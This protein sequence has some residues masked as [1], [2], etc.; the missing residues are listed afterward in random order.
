MAPDV[1]SEKRQA[2]KAVKTVQ[3]NLSLTSAVPA[4]FSEE[5]YRG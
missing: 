1:V 5:A 2:E 4:A 3:E